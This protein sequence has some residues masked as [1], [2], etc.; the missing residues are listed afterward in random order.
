MERETLKASTEKKVKNLRTCIIRIKSLIPV[1]QRRKGKK[2][3]V[4][5]LGKDGRDGVETSV[6]KEKTSSWEK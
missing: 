3:L 4:L 6:K 2:K 1:M 5:S